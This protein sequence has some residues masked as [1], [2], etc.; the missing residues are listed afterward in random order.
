MF[1]GSGHVKP[2]EFD[3]LLE[4]AGGDNNG[5]TENDRT[6]YWINVPSNA[7]EL[8]LFLESDRMGYLLDTMTP[9]D[10]RRAARRRQER[11][12]PELREPA[13]RD[14]GHH[15]GR[16]AVS[17]RASV[18]LAG[19][20]LH[21]GPH[22]RELR[23]CGGVFQE[24][25]RAVERQPRRRGRPRHGRD[26]RRLIEKWFG[27]VKPGPPVEPTTIPGV[28]LTGV[29][30]KTITDRVQLPRLYLAWLTP[31]HFEPGD[32]AL[33]VVA[34][35]LAGGKNSRLYKR[36][37]YD[38]QIAQDVVGVPE[39]VG[40]SRRTSR[41]RSRRG[42]ATP[43][44]RCRRSIDEEIAKL[45]REAPTRARARSSLNQIESS[46]YNRMERVGGFGGKADQ[47]NAYYTETGDPDWFNEDL[48]R[49]RALSPS[50]IRAAARRFLPRDR[51]VELI[52]DAG[53]QSVS[54]NAS[55]VRRGVQPH[56][57]LTCLGLVRRS[58]E[59]HAVY[60]MR[61]IIAVLVASVGA[62]RAGARPHADR[63][64][65][66]P[67]P[68]LKLPAIQKR[69][70]SNGLPV[71]IV[72][73]HEVP[74]A[75]VN[76]VVFSGSA[77]DPP[78]KFGVTSLMAAML[79]EGAGSRSALEIADAVDF[80]G[81]DLGAAQHLR[82]LG[83]PAARAGGAAGRR[84]ADHGRR[85]AAADV[86]AGRARTAAPAAAHGAAAGARRSGRPS[87]RRRSRASCTARRTATAR[88]DGRH[89]RDDQGVHRR[90]SARALHGGVPAG[91]RRAARGRRHRPPTR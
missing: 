57:T 64:A 28:A 25:L 24:V 85:R 62:R 44:T 12:A 16:D 46:F 15:A 56:A 66:G 47:L 11:A 90:R 17:R 72:E 45:Q 78:G 29:Q 37:V 20:R 43:S 68:T 8:A 82:L 18:P 9:Q 84:A 35:V 59:T 6:N 41:S 83:G 69:Q 48:G 3:K 10:R 65:P 51:R 88:R 67:P 50:D 91:Q 1:M 86:P 54:P 73:L 30:K 33:D 75:Q 31:R 55:D 61:S 60:A 32:A 38:M 53:R 49:Y 70:L 76:L 80:L 14:G 39:L 22:R 5:S 40:R 63:R 26:A 42:R 19:H 7:L 52:V 81:A 89:R 34:D 2:G 79:E 23:G 77:D 4:A 13:V 27:D 74:V 71:W 87:P 21:A 58:D 36:L